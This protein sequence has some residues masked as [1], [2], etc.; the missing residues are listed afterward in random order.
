M[1]TLIERCYHQTIKLMTEDK[2]FSSELCIAY[3]SL[4]E[5]QQYAETF[6]HPH[7]LAYFKTLVYEKR[8]L[9]YLLGHYI[10]KQALVSHNTTLRLND[11]LID[12]GVFKN[13]I[14]FHAENNKIQV[15]YSHAEHCGIALAFPEACPLG[16]DIEKTDAEKISDRN[17][18]DPR[19]KKNSLTHS[20]TLIQKNYLHFFGQSKKH[21]QKYCIRA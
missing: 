16:I 5:L 21:C 1:I 7:E 8:Q 11:I 17:T 15:T 6:L 4:S 14:I 9:S 18:T 2:S 10:A 19:R 12:Y 13:P 3:S 20:M